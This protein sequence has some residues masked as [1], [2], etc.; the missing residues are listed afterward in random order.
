MTWSECTN[1]AIYQHDAAIAVRRKLADTVKMQIGPATM[2]ITIAFRFLDQ[3][4]GNGGRHRWGDGGSDHRGTV[5]NATVDG[6]VVTVS[7]EKKV[8]DVAGKAMVVDVTL[9]FMAML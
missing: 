9:E 4:S 3:S 1:G 7:I 5:P 6:M 8:V 2:G